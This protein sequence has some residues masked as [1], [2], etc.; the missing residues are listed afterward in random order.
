MNSYTITGRVLRGKATA[1]LV[2]VNSETGESEWLSPSLIIERIVTGDV[3]FTEVGVSRTPVYVVSGP[4]RGT[5]LRS[6]RS[7]SLDDNLSNLP[8]R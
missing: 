8:L 5:Y 6:A 4:E 2:V 1:F 7:D 3:F